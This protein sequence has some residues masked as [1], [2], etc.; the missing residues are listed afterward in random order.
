MRIIS[1][2]RL[3]PGLS[4]GLYV[5]MLTSV[6]SNCEWCCKMTGFREPYHIRI[7]I[8]RMNMQPLDSCLRLWRGEGGEG[9][10]KA[11]FTR[12]ARERMID[13]VKNSFYIWTEQR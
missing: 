3:L 10:L 6:D 7:S 2:R 8:P 13:I 4:V 5:K 11:I 12:S 1:V 9:L